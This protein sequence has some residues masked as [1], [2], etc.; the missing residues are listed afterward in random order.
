MFTQ[1]EQIERVIKRIR[2]GKEAAKLRHREYYE[3]HKVRRNIDSERIADNLRLEVLQHYCGS[4]TP[5]C[6][7]PGCKETT[8]EFLSIDHV[9]G[10]GERHRKEI[11][12]SYINYWLRNNNYPPGFQ[13]LC[14]NCNQAKGC[15]RRCP[16]QTR[17]L[18]YENC[19]GY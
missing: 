14:H 4:G 16:H 7:C 10:G 12:S 8:L 15:Y 6:M 9:N 17:V 1:A 19:D 5:F 11:G 2:D 18:G 3:T 13:V